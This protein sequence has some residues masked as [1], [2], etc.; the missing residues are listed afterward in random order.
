MEVDDGVA[1]VEEEASERSQPSEVE[2]AVGPEVVDRGPAVPQFAGQ[3]VGSA[4]HERHLELEGPVVPGGHGVHEQAL[5]TAVA[6]ALDGQQ[7]RGRPR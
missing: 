2:A 6:Q 3:R 1:V 4:E 7:D 5:G